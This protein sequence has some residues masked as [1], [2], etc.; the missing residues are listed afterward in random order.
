MSR[1][2]PFSSQSGLS[3]IELMISVTLGIVLS[4][5]AVEI[6]VGSKQT[7]RT[8][9]ALSRMQENARYAL[10]LLIKDIRNTGYIGCGNLTNITPNIVD[11]AISAYDLSTVFTGN[12]STGAQS[13][14]PS[15]LPTG[16]A[17]VADHTDIVTVNSAGRCTT[18]LTA[19]MTAVDS[20]IS[21]ATTNSCGF[22]EH[23]VV[24]VSDCTKAD[25]FKITNV[26]AAT[27]LLSHADLA[28][29][30]TAAEAPDIMS[31]KSVTYFIR[32][33]TTSGIPSLFLMDNTRGVNTGTTNPNPV[34][35]IEGVE[36]MQIQYG[37][38]N[39]D[40]G[41]PEQYSNAS[42]STAWDKVVTAR[43]TLLMRTIE[44][45]NAG[46]HTFTPDGITNVT[47]NDGVMRKEFVATVQL[48][49]R[50]LDL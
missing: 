36:N 44:N 23:D 49:N 41:T 29:V 20:D 12:Q 26:P 5:G 18:P 48:R 22:G 47:Y 2:S 42:S 4:F 6:Y 19:D 34:A 21:I 7:Y 35:L 46:A 39:D 37:I 50:G 30:Y 24:M 8:Q 31:F 25:I 16:V 43:I 13:W 14:V 40:D 15:A 10:D 27:G 33:D 32:N 17:S 28:N 1:R 45:L 38:D 3:L 9:D 11:T